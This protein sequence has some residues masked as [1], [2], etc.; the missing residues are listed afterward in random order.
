MTSSLAK[1]NI[2]Q[3]IEDYS[4]DSANDSAISQLNDSLYPL[5]VSVGMNSLLVAFMIGNF[6][7]SGFT[8]G[9]PLR[10]TKVSTH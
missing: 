7:L 1:D 4:Y 2:N 5:N 3:T 8:L 10:S 6:I 9:Q